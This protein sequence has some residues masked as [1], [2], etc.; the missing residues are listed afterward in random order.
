MSL[1]ALDAC[2][3]QQSTKDCYVIQQFMYN[4]YKQ[5]RPYLSVGIMDVPIHQNCIENV[6]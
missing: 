3:S 5:F 4:I 1:F 2:K 6:R